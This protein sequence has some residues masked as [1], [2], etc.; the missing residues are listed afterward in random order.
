MTRL[1]APIYL[2]TI[3]VPAYT[4]VGKQSGTGHAARS[5]KALYG[6]LSAVLQ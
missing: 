6:V 2:S 5:R 1:C 3:H 4:L